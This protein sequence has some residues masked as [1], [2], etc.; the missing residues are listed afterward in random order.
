M[1]IFRYL[2]NFGL[3]P[4]TC[5]HFRSPGILVVRVSSLGVGIKVLYCN[6]CT[7]GTTG[8]VLASTMDETERATCIKGRIMLS[9]KPK[10]I[11]LPI[12]ADWFIRRITH[13]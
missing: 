2:L 10:R 11:V 1:L 7:T 9:L 3:A 13:V 12:S 6:R 4:D 8:S 5:P